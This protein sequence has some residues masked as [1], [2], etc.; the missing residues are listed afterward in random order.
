MKILTRAHTS[1]RRL[2]EI[3]RVIDENDK[4]IGARAISDVLSSR[5]YELGERAVRYNLKILDELGFTK[6]H[7]YSGRVLTQLGINEL[8]DALV[9]DRIGFVNTRIEEYMYR[10]SFSPELMNGDVIA[11]I[12]L[13]DKNDSEKAIE[14]VDRA[15]EAGYTL[16]RRMLLFDG[17]EMP[18]FS[19]PEGCLGIATICSITVDGM[20]LKRGVPVNTS[21]AGIIEVKDGEMNSFSD[22]VAYA[23]TSLDPMKVF[24][25]RKM[26][27]IG[28]AIIKGNGKV[29]ANV[30]EVPLAAEE[31]AMKIL[32][33]LKE[34]GIGGTIIIGEQGESLL[35]CPVSPGKIGIALCAGVN[36]VVFAEEMGLRI[37]TMPISTLMDYRLMK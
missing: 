10:T 14:A 35:G 28:D 23:G 3:L 18:Y 8:K 34:A 27:R 31:S 11:N 7:G 15:F 9:N 37:K 20:F 6:K 24:M 2:I 1:Q 32:E 29:L 21:F 17:E 33:L 36:G 13:V 30:R 22:L 25:A 5:G 26:T 16:C 12:S 4:P 19:V